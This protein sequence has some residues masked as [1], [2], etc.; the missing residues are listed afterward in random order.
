MA[1]R[2]GSLRATTQWKSHPQDP[3]TSIEA[4]GSLMFPFSFCGVEHAASALPVSNYFDCG[5]ADNTSCVG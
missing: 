1:E 5:S 2:Y 4:C 3:K